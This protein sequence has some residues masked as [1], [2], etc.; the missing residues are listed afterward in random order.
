MRVDALMTTANHANAATIFVAN[1]A[2][3]TTAR[4]ADW[5]A[6]FGTADEDQQSC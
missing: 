5:R 1:L 6:L 2:D 4:Q 3:G